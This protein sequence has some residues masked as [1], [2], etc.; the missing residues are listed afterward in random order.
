MSKR[1]LRAATRSS[2][3]ALWQTNAVAEALGTDVEVEVVKVETLG[4]KRRDIP[5][6]ALRGRGVFVKEV[7]HAVL[8]GHADFAVHSAKDLPSQTGP[9]LYLAS[10]PE[11]GDP[12][13]AMVGSSI[14]DLPSGALV[15]TGS[16]RRRAQ[17]ANMR[18]DVTFADLRGNVET[19]LRKA[20]DFDAIILANAGMTR[21]GL[22]VDAHPMK[23]SYFIPQVGQG[24]LAVE[25]R[26]SEPD[27]IALLSA[28][29]HGPSRRAVDAERAFLAELGGGCDLPVGAYA[30]CDDSGVHLRVF[31]SSLD[32][33]VLLRAN[34]S[35]TDGVALGKALADHLLYEAG[36]AQLLFDHRANVVR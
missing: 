13:D 26:A 28:I 23:P 17:L 3:L 36:G 16:V 31:L 29:E 30:T 24:A 2:N 33:R 18:P 6:E 14:A 34:E 19:R 11:R 12:R 15:A 27:V 25:C 35:G 10:V 9:G 1:V 8:D 32:G 22:G 4:D 20:V 7:Q 5:I 21:L